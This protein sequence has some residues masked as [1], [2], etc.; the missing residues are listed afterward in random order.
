MLGEEQWTWLEKQLL[1][2]ADVRI[3]ASS[4]Q[5]VSYEKRMECWG[6]L[7]HERQKLFDLIG[8]TKANGVIFIS[9]DVH[10]S[11]ISL[12]KSGPYPL[13]DHTSSGLTNVHP[14]WAS[15]V[16]SYRIG[17]SYAKLN[18]GLITIDWQAKNILLETKSIEGESPLKQTIA[19]SSLTVK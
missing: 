9:G 8:K 18:F 6:N 11:E 16:N 2:K 17:N 7:P 12:D 15:A 4:I 13:Y 19:L 3:I 5:V 14:G 10:F 1:K